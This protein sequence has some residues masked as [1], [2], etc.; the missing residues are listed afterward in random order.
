M[1]AR[2]TT[3]LVAIAAT[4]VTGLWLVHSALSSGDVD[5]AIAQK[6]TLIFGVEVSGTLKAVESSQIGPP[7]VQHLHRF[8]I[9]MMAPE[10]EAVSKDQPIVAFDT[11]ELQDRLRRFRNEVAEAETKVKKEEVTLAV[12]IS[13]DTLAMAEAEARLRKARMADARPSDLFASIERDKAALDLEMAELEAE[14]LTRRIAFSQAAAEARID[15]LRADLSTARSEV[16]RID[17]AI[18]SMTRT[19]PRDGV[20]TYTTNWRNEKKKV[21]DTCWRHEIV[22]EIPDLASMMADG[23]VEEALSGRIT[24]GQEVELHLDAHQDVT[25]RGVV[26]RVVRA[27][28]EKSWRNPLKV[29]R[30][31]IGLKT[32]DPDR[33]RPGMRFKGTI[34]V[35]RKNEVL[36]IPVLSVFTSPNGPVAR[37]QTFR[38]SRPAPLQLGDS[39]G[40]AIEV[41]EGLEEGDRVVT[42]RAPA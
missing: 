26:T 16:R 4:L 23:E 10:G 37:V 39:D 12:Q 3:V 38:G 18:R 31:E 28:Q 6:G 1:R 17:Q 5:V 25:Y 41:L 30:V 21:G 19:A 36:L 32:T 11:S 33:M 9:S 13:D 15:A 20:V 35:G 24:E 40:D 7:T 29:V 42:A 8:K 27:V 22:L 2:R 14:R 34:E